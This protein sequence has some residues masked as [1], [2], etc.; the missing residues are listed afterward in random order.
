MEHYRVFMQHSVIQQPL[1]QL[2]SKMEAPM[3]PLIFAVSAE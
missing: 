1:I 2:E 3:Y